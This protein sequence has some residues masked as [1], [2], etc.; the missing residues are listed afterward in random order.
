[1]S[2]N[3][4]AALMEQLAALRAQLADDDEQEARESAAM[5]QAELSHMAEMERHIA[6]VNAQNAALEQEIAETDRRQTVDRF[7]QNVPTPDSIFGDSLRR[8]P[9][10]ILAK[11]HSPDIMPTFSIEASHHRRESAPGKSVP[12]KR[13]RDQ[14]GAREGARSG[15]TVADHVPCFERTKRQLCQR[16]RSGTGDFVWHG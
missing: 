8:R 15:I 10:R 4:V 16:A 12:R 3:S 2:S 6:A 9:G 5:A 11:G 13:P 14:S 1:M 7:L